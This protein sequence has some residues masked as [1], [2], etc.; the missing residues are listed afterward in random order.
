MER[1]QQRLFL[2]DEAIC[3]RHIRVGQTGVSPF[4][5]ASVSTRNSQGSLLNQGHA[6][7]TQYYCDK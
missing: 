1:L 3:K 2:H 7:M 4:T 6:L 5:G